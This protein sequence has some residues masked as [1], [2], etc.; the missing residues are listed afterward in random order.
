MHTY[1]SLS[2]LAIDSGRIPPHCVVTLNCGSSVEA[3]CSATKSFKLEAV[4]EVRDLID[5]AAE[6]YAQ[7]FDELVADGWKLT[8]SEECPEAEGSGHV[9]A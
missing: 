1:R 2:V 5:W 9:E 6:A 4:S 8:H 3:H 7:A